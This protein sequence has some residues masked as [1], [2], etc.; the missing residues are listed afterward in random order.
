MATHEKAISVGIVG[1]S[2]YTG[3]E[4]ARW[5]ARHRGFRLTCAMSRS[6]AGQPLASF[7][8]F[9][10]QDQP[11]VVETPD[12]AKA[13]GVEILFL[14]LPH[15][16]S[17]AFVAAMDEGHAKVVDLSADFRLKDAA[18]YEAV[19]GEAHRAAD[20]LP[21]AVY[22][23]TEFCRPALKN[24]RLVAN[25]GCYPTCSG[26][27]LRPLMPLA[28]LSQPV[29]VDAKSGVSGAGKS[30]REDLL[31]NECA[32]SL[33]PYG[34]VGHRHTAEIRHL[35]QDAAGAPVRVSF[36]PHLLPVVRGMSATCYVA[37]KAGKTEDDAREVLCRAYPDEPFVK[38]LNSGDW[39]DIKRV[40]NTNLCLINLAFDPAAGLLKVFSV[41]DNLVKGASGQAI[42]NANVMAGFAETEGLT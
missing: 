42:Q 18:E 25:P 24:A 1:I 30:L 33:R 27:A 37:M 21:G 12:P 8:P 38:V 40:T 2:G 16:E 10:P 3:Q 6:W 28:D 7:Y 14:A 17:M 32:Q 39:P 41:I 34:V 31:F 35:L 23:L 13:G 22:G 15:H 4:L 26:L 20:R 11:L 19:Y 9:W 36:T 29:I 5:L